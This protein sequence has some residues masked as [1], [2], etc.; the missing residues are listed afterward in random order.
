MAVVTVST[1]TVKPDRYD[2]FLADARKAKALLEKHGAKNVRVMA[3]LVAGEATGS[4]ASIVEAD[5]WAASG[6]FNDRF[7]ADPEG[8]AFLAS[9][10]S[11]ASPIGAA[12]VSIWVDVPL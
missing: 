10:S 3:A 11:G 1:Y 2:D 6:A 8:Q 4:M 12:N 5:D 7:Q 9:L